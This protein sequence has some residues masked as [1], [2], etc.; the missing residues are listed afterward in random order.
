MKKRKKNVAKIM[1]NKIMRDLMEKQEYAGLRDKNKSG[2]MKIG[3]WEN[4]M[5]N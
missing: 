2:T 4:L 5:M 3:K 1:I